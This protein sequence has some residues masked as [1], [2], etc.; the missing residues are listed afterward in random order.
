MKR[1]FKSLLAP[2]FEEFVQRKEAE[3]KWSG[4]SE[5][6]LHSFDNYITR[7]FPYERKLNAEML[8]WCKQRPT[9]QDIS[10]RCR[11][12][13]VWMFVE[14][15]KKCN[16]TDCS[17]Q[18]CIS[19]A[20]SSFK[21]HYFSREELYKFFQICDSHVLEIYDQCKTFNSKLNRLELPVFFRLLYSSGMRTCEARWL[22]CS[23]VNLE[24]GVINIERSKGGSQHRVAL[25]E[26]MLNLLREYHKAMTKL[27]PNRET[28]FPNS[29]DCPHLPEW[30][31]F[32]FRNIWRKVS[33][34]AARCYD[35]RHLYAVTNISSWSNHGYEL[36]GKLLFLS[37]SMG[38]NDIQSTF[39][40]F[41]VTPM[42]KDKLRANSSDN[43][44]NVLPV[45]PDA[46]EY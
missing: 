34:E 15:A 39:S 16:W 13:I 45:Y 6:N 25:H 28:F 36:S 31:G 1:P 26:T 35:F 29:H 19:Y 14:Y 2:Q 24:E 9:E 41:H 40:Y 30:E 7:N 27:M 32:H 37:R 23:D 42:L 21:P 17:V 43:F 33:D 38:H 11:S 46:Y 18:R 44:N 4:T 20:P 12:S 3:G 5:T 10:C 22:K 8:E